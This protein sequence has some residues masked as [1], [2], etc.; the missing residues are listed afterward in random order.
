M[1]ELVFFLCD[2]CMYHQKLHVI[3]SHQQI[4]CSKFSVPKTQCSRKRVW[5]ISVAQIVAIKKKDKCISVIKTKYCAELTHAGEVFTE[6][7]RL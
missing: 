7:D 6:V 1:L 3:L 4:S 2:M 5:V